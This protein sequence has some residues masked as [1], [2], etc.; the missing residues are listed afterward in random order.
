VTLPNILALLLVAAAAFAAGA[1]GA[2]LFSKQGRGPL[3]KSIRTL[4][5]QWKDAMSELSGSRRRVS[6]L[7]VE[8]ARLEERSAAEK[9][10]S[11]TMRAS[12]PDTF[13]A[14]ASQVLQEKSQEF[15]EQNQTSLGQMLEPLKTKLE[16]FRQ[17]HLE[18]V[19]DNA[20]LHTQI[21]GLRESTAKVSDEANSLANALKGSNKTQGNWGELI[22]E[23]IL[24][25]AGLRRGEEYETQES[26]AAEN[27]RR[28][29]PDV[30]IHLPGERHIVIDAKVSLTAYEAHANAETDPARNA[31]LS[32][33]LRSVRAHI[34]GLT[35]KNYQ[36]LYGLKS[37]DFVIMFM[38]I[39][40]AFMLALSGDDKLWQQA[41]QKNLLLVSPSTLLFVLRTVAY[42]WRQE[43]QERNVEE[44]ARRGAELYNKL[45]GFVESLTEVGDRLA[46][47]QK[48]YENAFSR[49]STGRGNVIRQAEILKALG[50]KP[51]KQL[52]QGLVEQAG[53]ETLELQAGPEI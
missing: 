14:L 43:Q 46:Q 35:E 10:A 7:E 40:P 5:A 18:Q 47:A 19:K 3:E 17:L 25:S 32:E 52:P 49:L 23:K 13:K 36:T 1:V 30:V 51:G 45:A 8:I 12:F 41:W 31:A 22:L 4:D 26:Y 39:E 50:V 53:Q 24:E 27:G 44:I 2:W 29:Q 9:R 34:K 21:T 6:D 16:D 11:E 28:S 48:S 42:L 15:A 33:H 37:L 20:A 38:P